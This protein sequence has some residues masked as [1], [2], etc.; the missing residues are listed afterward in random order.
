MAEIARKKKTGI[1]SKP[2]KPETYDMDKKF[3]IIGDNL[4]YM[5]LVKV[6]G[7]FCEYVFEYFDASR[8]PSAG[9]FLPALE[10]YSADGF[11]GVILSGQDGIELSKHIRISNTLG[12]LSLL[13]IMIFSPFSLEYH[14][15]ERRDNIFLLSPG[16]YLIP[17]SECVAELLIAMEEPRPFVSLEEM[18]AGLKP[19]IV[20]S[21]E[22]NVVSHHDNFN[23]YGPVKLMQ[24]HFGQIPDD[25][26]KYFTN[27]N[28]KL[29]FRKYQFLTG[30]DKR[31]V[32]A[33]EPDE[34]LFKRLIA[35]KKFLYIDDEHRLGWFFALQA[36]LG[37]TDEPEDHIFFNQVGHVVHATNGRFTCLD[38]FDTAVEVFNSY[39]VELEKALAE[40]SEAEHARNTVAEQFATAQKEV[41]D[42]RLKLNSVKDNH[43]RSSAGMEESESRLR[44]LQEELKKSIFSL[45]DAYTNDVQVPEMLPAIRNMKDMSDQYFRE[46]ST[47]NRHK[48]DTEKHGR[49]LEELQKEV[50]QREDVFKD[51]QSRKDLAVKRYDRAVF[52][53]S[54]K[55]LFSFDLVICDL[56]LDKVNDIGASPN[57]ISGVRLLRQIKKI[58]P[59]IPVLIFTA[60]EKAMNYKEVIDLGASGYWIKSVNSL[61]DLKIEVVNSL[62]KAQDARILWQ[63]I[64]KVEARRELSLFRENP[65]TKALERDVMEKSRKVEIGFLLRESFL[66]LLRK[67]SP[68]EYL[69]CNFS[70]DAKIAL[71][72]GLIQEERFGR[73]EGVK[74]DL[75]VK[76]KKIDDDEA[77]IRR[78]RNKAAHQAKTGMTYCEVLNI[79]QKT[80]DKCLR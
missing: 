24:E 4:I 71:N 66:L 31:S 76:Q 46:E 58:D 14:L 21:E 33:P 40:Y 19:F 69:V 27:I 26:S 70:N 73:I 51:A 7:L 62:S 74:W 22:D 75:L 18:R 44:K 43:A 30:E 9:S 39:G 77:M 41:N 72:M 12:D 78:I 67:A 37:G 45:T 10:E 80:L 29:W 61:D 2:H 57:E 6:M 32:K 50:S 52:A 49:S 48:G 79:F 8:F 55:K 60:S 42:T 38:D 11:H 25:Y 64:R 63:K 16:I 20:W 5:T 53:L 35:N 59:S 36:I 34:A 65:S 54:T 56:R 68:Y 1:L 47:F 3:L 17:V 15:R 13:P 23:R 28:S